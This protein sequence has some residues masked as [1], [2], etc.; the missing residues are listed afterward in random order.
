M[1]SAVDAAAQAAGADS[2]RLSDALIWSCECANC[3]RTDAARAVELQRA[4]DVSEAITFCLQCRSQAIR[5]EIRDEFEPGELSARFPAGAAIPARFAIVGDDCIDLQPPATA[6]GEPGANEIRP[7]DFRA[8]DSGTTDPQPTH[9]Q[10]TDSR[11]GDIPTTST[12]QTT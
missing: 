10:P 4:A 1:A 7:N 11:T 9:L 6:G 12:E 2:M 8:E 5:V 3:G